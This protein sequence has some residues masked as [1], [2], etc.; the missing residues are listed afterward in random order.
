[1]KPKEYKKCQKELNKLKRVRATFIKNVKKEI[2]TA[3]S[4]KIGNYNLD[5]RVKSIYSIYKKMQSKHLENL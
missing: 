1:L 4:E 3:L 2:D 5:F